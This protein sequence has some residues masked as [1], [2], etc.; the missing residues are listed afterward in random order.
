MEDEWCY[1]KVI[2]V[3]LV[4][5][6]CFGCP[7]LC[8]FCDQQVPGDSFITSFRGIRTFLHTTPT[9]YGQASISF[10]GTIVCSEV[11]LI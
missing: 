5:V 10:D 6:F 9:Y 4:V 11:K 8:W 7:A 3:E 1:E 2:M